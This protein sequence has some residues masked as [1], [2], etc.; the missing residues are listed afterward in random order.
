MDADSIRDLFQEI[1]PVQ[2]RR[3]FG[4]QG[5]YRDGMMF[6]LEAGGELYLKADP[7]TQDIFRDLG[8]RPFAYTSRDGRTTT[9]SYWLLPDSA[10]DDPD[11]A[12]DLARVAIEAARRTKKTAKK[13]GGHAMPPRSTAKAR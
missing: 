4:G 12:A 6:A 10:L 3:M 9:M 5:I 2:I 1:G 11:A 13:K 8:S 7:Q